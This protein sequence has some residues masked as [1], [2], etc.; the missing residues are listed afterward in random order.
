M[1][2]NVCWLGAFSH[3]K[4]SA[5]MVV[6]KSFKLS[7]N[8]LLCTNCL[9]VHQCVCVRTLIFHRVYSVT[10]KKISS[11]VTCVKIMQN[12]N[13][14]IRLINYSSLYFWR[15]YFRASV[16]FISFCQFA[17]KT[18]LVRLI[19]HVAKNIPWIKNSKV[20]QATSIKYFRI[21]FWCRFFSDSTFRT[22]SK[23]LPK[24][25]IMYSFFF[26][27]INFHS[28]QQIMFQIKR[29]CGHLFLL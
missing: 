2:P 8:F 6:L 13:R 21:R 27:V 22:L 12:P 10:K 17:N 16:W 26:H 1:L 24:V 25:S 5:S 4:S 29:F 7:V 28:Q 20:A 18:E 19:F 9:P 15:L 3:R 11:F 14:E 23:L